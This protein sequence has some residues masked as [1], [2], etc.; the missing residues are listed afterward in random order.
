[1]RNDNNAGEFDA[2]SAGSGVDNPLGAAT[3]GAGPAARP[4]IGVRAGI[5]AGL[6]LGVAS[7][8]VVTMDI[9]TVVS[10][11]THA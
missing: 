8:A 9:S 1:M 5:L 11:H 4:K 7:V 3:P 10:N 2:T 6:T